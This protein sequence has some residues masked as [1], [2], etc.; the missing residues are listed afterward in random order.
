MT[1]CKTIFRNLL[2]LVAG[3][4]LLTGTARAVLNI[5]ITQGREGGVPIAVVPFLWTGP[6]PAPDQDVSAVVA[7]DLQRSGRFKLLPEKD[8]LAHPH[9]GRE[10]NF[11]NWRALGVDDLV[12]GKV[13]PA[14]PGHYKVQFQLFDIYKTASGKDI[15]KPEYEIKQLAGYSLACSTAQLR[16]TAH[17]ISDI[18]YKQ[19]TGERG[20][21]NTKIAY[22]TVTRKDGKATYTLQVADADGYNPHQVLRSDAPI[23]SPSWSPDGKRLAYVSFERGTPAI[24][25]QNLATGTRQ[26]VSAHKGINGAPAWS[27]D[28]KRLALTL[29]FAD[30]GNAEVYVMDLA[31]RALHRI[32]YNSAIDT[33]PAWSPDGKTLVFTSDR[34]GSP[35]LYRVPA[36]GGHPQRLTFDGNYNSRAA[37]S[38]DGNMLAMVHQTKEGFRI[39]VLNL[40]TGLFR[41]LT[42]GFVDESPSFAPNG[43]MILYATEYHNR[44]VLA[45]VSVDGRVHE[46]LVLQEGN[47]R[48]PAWGPFTDH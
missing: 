2:L 24:Y 23:M 48:E 32:T 41:V 35:Q 16:S 27:P 11:E 30:P 39:A 47:V 28:G 19:L 4:L 44:G 26:M 3:C 9:D 7:A 29:S 10:V 17:S 22:I 36:D 20:A 12:V 14:G 15:G 6:G 46:R 37:F 21:F 43:S 25:V 31:T 45:A 18:I 33:E 8:F 42:N 1:M 38:P 34:S 13:L 5:Q 40:K